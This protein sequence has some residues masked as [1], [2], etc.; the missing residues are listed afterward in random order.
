MIF[1]LCGVYPIR[2]DAPLTFTEAWN[3]YKLLFSAAS[4]SRRFRAVLTGASDLWTSIIFAPFRRGDVDVVKHMVEW[5]RGRPLHVL[6]D[7]RGIRAHAS[8]ACVETLCAIDKERVYTLSI[9]LSHQGMDLTS[10]VFEN[11]FR[12][13]QKL[14]KT[15]IKCH[16]GCLKVPFVP[17][18]PSTTDITISSISPIT[19]LNRYVEIEFPFPS[20]NNIQSLTLQVLVSHNV[21]EE[22]LTHCGALRHLEWVIPVDPSSDFEWPMPDEGDEEFETHKFSLSLP[23]RLSS[24]K[25][26]H[27]F[28]VPVLCG[29]GLTNV[30]LDVHDHRDQ[31][32]TQYENWFVTDPPHV[33]RMRKF[34]I[35]CTCLAMNRVFGDM[36]HSARLVLEDVK[37]GVISARLPETLLAAL[38]LLHSAPSLVSISFGVYPCVAFHGRWSDVVMRMEELLAESNGLFFHVACVERQLPTSMEDLIDSGRDGNRVIIHYFAETSQLYRKIRNL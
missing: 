4:V 20:S 7:C 31:E 15:V 3:R 13:L 8:T 6:W 37:L 33:P 5:S 24:L 35:S 17:C 9:R 36:F 21:L 30:R 26:S 18:V 23:K 27:P 32:N 22:Y 34:S 29:E 14:R 28:L 2:L 25:I 11:R 1:L 16:D 10:G 38:E 19:Q 12:P